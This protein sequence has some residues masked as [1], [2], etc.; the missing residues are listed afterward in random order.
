MLASA[1]LAAAPTAAAR[2]A[3][4][5]APH[6]AVPP[7]RGHVSDFAGVID[8]GTRQALETRIAELREATG[9]EIAVVTVRST[10]PESVFDYAMAIAESWKPG[11]AGKDTGV[12]FLVSVDDRQVQ[13]L[14]GYG[15]EGALPDGKVGEIRDSL[16]LPA[17]RRGDYAGGIARATEALAQVIAAST[18]VRLRASP[19]AAAPEPGHQGGG[20]GEDPT[21]P[22]VALVVLI[23]LLRLLSAV[24]GALGTFRGSHRRGGLD[25]LLGGPYG[26]TGFGRTTSRVS[27]GGGL[28]GGSSRFGGFGGGRFGGG[29]AGGSW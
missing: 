1:L 28:G 12:V 18:G 6:I 14:T 10:K 11:A 26:G 19:L 16:A 4:A 3:V 22:I 29:G 5:P 13:I 24:R 17:F 8:G 7:P 20:A 25:T 9:A 15:V 23:A 27:F 2:S 21:W